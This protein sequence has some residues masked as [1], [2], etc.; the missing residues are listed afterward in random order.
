VT[1]SGPTAY[2]VSVWYSTV[3]G[4]AG[5]PDDFTATAGILETS[6]GLTS[7]AIQVPVIADAV[8][9]ASEVFYVD[10]GSPVNA[11]IGTYRGAVT[12]HN[13][14]GSRVAHDY[15]GDAKADLTVYRPTDRTWWV[16]RDSSTWYHYLY[17]WPTEGTPVP[18]DYDG[19]GRTDMATWRADTG[20]W[21]VRTS[22]SDFTQD[23]VFPQS[24]GLSG[25][26]PVPGDYDGDGRA[27]L[28]VWRPSTGVWWVLL[29]SQDYATSFTALWGNSGDQPVAGD[30]DGDGKHDVAVYRPSTGLWYVI[31]S[32]T[33]TGWSPVQWGEPVPG[34]YNGD[35]TTD[36]AV[37]RPGVGM[38][39]VHGQFTA[40]WGW[41]DDLPVAADFDGDGKTD[42]AVYR[43]STGDWHV[44]KSSSGNSVGQV[45]EWG[46][47]GD[48]PLPR[49]P[50]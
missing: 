20:V 19:D 36:V 15:D 31:Q 3:P 7:A 27:D 2:P 47:P 8:R 12:I 40:Q 44:L 50:Y 10:L 13:D 24:W 18:A 48:I 9:E 1:L 17:Q 5:T 43:P 11:T 35:G 30:Y 45:T 21:A 37:Y 34:D 22:A 4:A 49:V 16:L 28:A 41:P 6:A 38:W 29:S 14:D 25:D 39:Y 26:I 46:A 42:V 33:G 32:S 23:L